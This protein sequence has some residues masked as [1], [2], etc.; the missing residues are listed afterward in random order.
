MCRFALSS[1]VLFTLPRA[2]E[3]AR[4]R[5]HQGGTVVVLQPHKAKG[6]LVTF[7]S[8]KVQSSSLLRLGGL[9]EALLMNNY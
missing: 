5:H 1:A 9:H 4:R 3:E 6:P 8:V 7:C 2:L